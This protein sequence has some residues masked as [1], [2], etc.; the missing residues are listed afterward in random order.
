M[1]KEHEITLKT[2]NEKIDSFRRFT[3]DKLCKEIIKNG[4]ILRTSI[5]VTVKDY[6]DRLV[7][8]RCIFLGFDSKTHDAFYIGNPLFPFQFNGPPVFGEKEQKEIQ[9][10]TNIKNEEQLRKRFGDNI[11]DSNSDLL[12]I[13]Y[14]KPKTPKS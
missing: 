7:D 4:G 14:L 6:L 8:L 1:S 13:C 2:I 9:K 3:Y 12:K 10:D 5:M 11:V